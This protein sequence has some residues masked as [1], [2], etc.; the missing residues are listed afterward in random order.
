MSEWISEWMNEWMSEY[1]NEWINK[2]IKNE[3]MNDWMNEWTNGWM[4]ER[5]LLEPC[6]RL[7]DATNLQFTYQVW[8]L[9]RFFV[10]ATLSNAIKNE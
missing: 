3:V 4:N 8:Q 9:H 2:W 6:F 5:S 7:S 10:K 1:L